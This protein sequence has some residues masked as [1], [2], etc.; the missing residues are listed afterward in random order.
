MAHKIAIFLLLPLLLFSASAC[1]RYHMTPEGYYRPKKSK[2]KLKGGFV[3]DDITRQID[4]K[5]VYTSNDFSS[6]FASDSIVSFI[7]FFNDGRLYMGSFSSSDN[8]IEKIN[9]ISSIDVGYYTSKKG[10]LLIEVF[11]IFYDKFGDY[12][13]YTCEIRNG[14]IVILQERLRAGAKF[15]KTE[16]YNKEYIPLKDLT[17]DW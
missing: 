11:G 12:G 14:Q 13:T 10:K 3:L 16:I 6:Y 15:R 1:K 5:A 4:T 17:P 9:D 8:K 2:F 7:R